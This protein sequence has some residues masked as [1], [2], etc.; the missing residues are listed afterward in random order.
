MVKNS[1]TVQ[2]YV[3]VDRV[4]KKAFSGLI[5]AENDL[6]ADFGFIKWLKNQK[7]DV[8]PRSY[9]LRHVGSFGLSGE[10]VDVDNYLV[11]NGDQAQNFYDNEVIKALEE[12][13]N[14]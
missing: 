1:E 14:S 10:I 7:D 4:S 6:V 11:V 8:D 2:L 13:E 3:I 9:A 5:P 12:E